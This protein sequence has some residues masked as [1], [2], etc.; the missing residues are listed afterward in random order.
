MREGIFV[1]QLISF[2]PSVVHCAEKFRPFV[3]TVADPDSV[4]PDSD[5]DPDSEPGK[6]KKKYFLKKLFETFFL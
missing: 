6:K 1:V 2:K 4:N 5:P 3:S